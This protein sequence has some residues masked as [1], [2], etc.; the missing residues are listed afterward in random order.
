M[1]D[2]KIPDITSG[3][4]NKIRAITLLFLSMKFKGKKKRKKKK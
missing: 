1:S 2:L 4:A 3:L